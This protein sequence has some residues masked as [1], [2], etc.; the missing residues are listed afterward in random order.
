MIVSENFKYV[1]RS[2]FAVRI[3]STDRASTLGF[4]IVALIE[5]SKGCESVFTYNKHGR[6]SKDGT[7]NPLDLVLIEDLQ[8]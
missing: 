7:L 6:Y 2:G 4:S 3:I 5:L 8:V 1:T